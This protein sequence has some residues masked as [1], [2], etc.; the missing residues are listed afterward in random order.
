MTLTKIFATCAVA[1]MMTTVNAAEKVNET[2]VVSPS[3]NN[4]QTEYVYYN[5]N[6]TT[7]YVYNLDEQGRVASKIRYTLN[8]EGKWNPSIAYSVHYGENET[9]V[10]CAGWNAD[11][12]SF[13][14]NAKQIHL[15]AQE[16]PVAIQMPK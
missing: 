10:T 15:N 12:H 8:E 16:Y 2:S 7:K 6:S 1:F 4:S 5:G 9:T 11:A 3:A 14:K 13:T